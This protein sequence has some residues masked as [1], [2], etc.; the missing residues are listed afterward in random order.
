MAGSQYIGG[1]ARAKKDELS[2]TKMEAEVRRMARRL[3]KMAAWMEGRTPETPGWPP[4]KKAGHPSR[5]STAPAN[6]KR[7][8][9]AKKAVRT[10]KAMAVLQNI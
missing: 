8:Y 1:R 7:R 5:R 4:G 2:G 9:P 10:V 3:A 6:E